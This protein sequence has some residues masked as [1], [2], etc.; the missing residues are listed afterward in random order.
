MG[1]GATDV[2]AGDHSHVITDIG[3]RGALSELSTV[4]TS[5]IDNDAVTAAKL[6]PTT[7]GTDGQV[8]S[9]DSSGDLQWINSSAQSIPALRLLPTSIGTAKQVLRVNTSATAVEYSDLSVAK[10]ELNTTNSPAAGKILAI[11]QNGDMLWAEEGQIT[12]SADSISS[13]MIQDNTVTPIKISVFEN[14]M[15]STT[16]GHILVSNGEVFDNV[17]MSGD[18]RIDG[19]GL[20]TIQP[21]GPAKISVFDD[22]MTTTTSGD[23]LVSN[24]VAFDNVTMAG[25]AQISSAGVLTIKP[26]V[27]EYGMLAN[28]FTTR[29]AKIVLSS[30]NAEADINFKDHAVFEIDLPS[31]STNVTINMDNA[32]IGDTKVVIIN[33]KGGS[34]TITI[35]TNDIYVNGYNFVSQRLSSDDI[36]HTNTTVNYLQITCVNMAVTGSKF[37]YTVGTPQ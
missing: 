5:E 10:T 34:G 32:D 28:E 11:D 29:D 21:I 6:Q 12:L 23:L 2:A 33:G 14:N 36:D 17:T 9:I 31:D 8:L 25:D 20:T 22:S 7:V 35:S 37:I 16:A 1:T 15:T 30:S 26:D 19:D 27:I 24:G 13:G 18:V 3:D 4:G